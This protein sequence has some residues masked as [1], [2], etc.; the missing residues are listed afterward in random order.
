MSGQEAV[1]LSPR[2]QKIGFLLR[3]E[4]AVKGKDRLLAHLTRSKCHLQHPLY[5]GTY[6]RLRA[7]R[8][9]AGT[10][11]RTGKFDP[12]LALLFAQ[13]GAETLGKLPFAEGDRRT[14]C[15][16]WRPTSNDPRKAKRRGFRTNMN[17]I[18]N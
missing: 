12:E 5:V 17:G 3:A 14:R 13:V 15:G 11:W 2:C 1:R 16:R 10:A 7:N 6:C 4:T 8:G 9:R 18:E